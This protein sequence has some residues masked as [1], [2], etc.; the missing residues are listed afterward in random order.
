VGPNGDRISPPANGWRWSK[1][2]LEE[3]MATGEIRFS[4]DGKSI[5]RRTYFADHKGLPPSS[6]WADITKTGA[7]RQAKYE[8]KQL[9]SGQPTRELF[10]TP[11][12]ERLLQRIIHVATKPG[13][14]VLDCF[15]GSGT[16]AAV[17]HK[18]G[19][20]WITA[21]VLPAT[22]ATFT[23]QRLTK[24]ISGKDPGGI[25]TSVNWMGGGGFRQVVIA[26]S[27]YEIT[28]LG[29]MLSDWA[30]KDRFERAVAGQLGFEWQSTKHTPFCGV[31]GRMRLAVFDGAIGIEEVREV[32][33][34]LDDRDRVTIVAK[35]VLPGV[36]EFVVNQSKGS[37]VKKAPRDLLTGRTG[38]VHRKVGETT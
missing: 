13:D 17:A 15:G 7:S 33:A 30:T 5:K 27:M 8:L 14:I 20:R 28:P 11:K 25:T 9:Y 12:P 29:V 4:T 36:E 24:V 22:V 16:T 34:A 19:R 18:M 38:R 3:R 35:V 1:N 21:E 37:R 26:P 10:D 31:R 23:L 2:T 6:L 32:I